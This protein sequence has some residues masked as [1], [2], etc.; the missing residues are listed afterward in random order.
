MKRNNLEK[1]WRND[2]RAKEKGH[3]M[4]SQILLKH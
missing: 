3:L 4:T 2:Y 1:I